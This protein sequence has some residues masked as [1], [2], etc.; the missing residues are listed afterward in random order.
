MVNK[1]SQAE[2][3]DIM[4]KA[5][6]QMKENRHYRYGQA[7]WNLL[8]LEL[9]KDFTNTHVDFFHS[10]DEEYVNEILFDCFVK[11]Y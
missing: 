9:T 3:Q 10:R 4:A 1:L 11:L 7:V 8:P 6:E 5:K 2:A